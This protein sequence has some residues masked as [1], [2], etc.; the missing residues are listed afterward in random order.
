M[1]RFTALTPTKWAGI[2]CCGV[3]TGNAYAIGNGNAFVKEIVPA[4][5]VLNG[6][7]YILT[8]PQSE[9]K[10]NPLRPITVIF[11][12]LQAGYWVPAY[13]PDNV[14]P[15]TGDVLVTVPA[16]PDVNRRTGKIVIFNP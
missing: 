8:I 6:A 11:Y 15:V 4:D 2:N 7:V 9:H 12:E 1:G 5:Y 13:L 14:D 10:K 16:I 3:V